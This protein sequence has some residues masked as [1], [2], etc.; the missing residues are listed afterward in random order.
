V[1]RGKRMTQLPV[2]LPFLLKRKGLEAGRILFLGIEYPGLSFF[3][4]LGLDVF[5]D[6]KGEITGR[7]DRAPALRLMYLAPSS[8]VSP[9]SWRL[10]VNYLPASQCSVQTPADSRVDRIKP[11]LVPLQRL[12]YIICLLLSRRCGTRKEEI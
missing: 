3:F 7:R 2:F 12:V 5:L 9:S 4:L 10:P 11:C 6:S 8:L 1:R